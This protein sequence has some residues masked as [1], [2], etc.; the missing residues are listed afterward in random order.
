M[1]ADSPEDLD[2]EAIQEFLERKGAVELLIVLANRDYKHDELEAELPVS[3]STFHLR[4]EQ[5][6]DLGLIT[7]ESRNV[8]GSFEAFY[9]LT[10]VGRPIANHAR[11]EGLAKLFWRLQELQE[12]YRASPDLRYSHITKVTL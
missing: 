2:C 9:T 12:Q 10:A 3:G 11:G 5:A 4:R 1:P 6:S 7:K 8:D